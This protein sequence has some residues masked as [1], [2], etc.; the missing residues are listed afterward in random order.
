MHL[1]RT[2]ATVVLIFGAFAGCTSRAPLP[3]GAIRVPTD[4]DV[5]SYGSE[6]VLCDTATATVPEV[7]PTGVLAGDPSD[8][9]WPVWL[10]VEDGSRRYVLWPRDFSVRF[11]PGATLLDET[12]KAILYAG[13]PVIIADRSADTSRGTKDRPY[14]AVSFLT[15]LI[16]LPHCY[17]R[18]H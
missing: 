11:D 7:P 10:E 6:H 2:L 5:V 14:V 15:G 16:H 9:T 13:S 8:L 4:D 12:G 17:T 1:A 3:S 18:D